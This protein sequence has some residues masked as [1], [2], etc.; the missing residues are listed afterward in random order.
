MMM[1]GVKSVITQLARKPTAVGTV[2]EKRTIIRCGTECVRRHLSSSSGGGGGGGIATE[3]EGERQPGLGEDELQGLSPEEVLRVGVRT[4]EMWKDHVA[5]TTEFPDASLPP[6][7]DDSAVSPDA[8]RRK[9][10]V[11]RSKQ[12]GWLEVD[13]LLGSWAEKNVAGLSLAD[14]DRYEDILNLETVDIFNFI[15]GNA[16]PPAFVDTPM[17]ARLQAYVKSN[18]LGQSPASYASAKRESN[19]T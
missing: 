1:Q 8:V 12:R 9:R 6:G 18:P 7:G 15:T 4:Q 11:Y 19:L 10:L 13:L 14:M 17:M 2:F 3:W 5:L 16:E